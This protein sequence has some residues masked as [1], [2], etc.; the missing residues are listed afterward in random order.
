ML[1]SRT[2]VGRAY[3]ILCGFFWF[4]PVPGVPERAEINPAWHSWAQPFEP[5]AIFDLLYKP[6]CS[7][8][9]ITFFWFSRWL[10]SIQK[11]KA[12]ASEKPQQPQLLQTS[13]NSMIG[14]SAS[15]QPGWLQQSIAMSA[16]T[17]LP[18]QSL[19]GKREAV[20]KPEPN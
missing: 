3:N 8:C 17:A 20:I 10:G 4:S 19:P 9:S 11:Q 6:I 14:L 1:S 5:F 2:F 16:H 13:Q 7:L 12:M 18:G 15:F